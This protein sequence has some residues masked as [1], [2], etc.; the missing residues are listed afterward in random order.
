MSHFVDVPFYMRDENIITSGH[1]IRIMEGIFGDNGIKMGE[2]IVHK[3]MVSRASQKCLEK[4]YLF[5]DANLWPP[6]MHHISSL[7]LKINGFDKLEL[8]IVH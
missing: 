3:D 5:K 6:I 2:E 8:K 4:I 1:I 7:L